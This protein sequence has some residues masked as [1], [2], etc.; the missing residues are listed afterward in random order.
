MTPRHIRPAESGWLT[1]RG[2]TA[3]THEEYKHW[4]C[5]HFDADRSRRDWFYFVLNADLPVTTDTRAFY[6]HMT[7]CC[8]R[9]MKTCDPYF[10]LKHPA[11]YD[12]G[13]A[14]SVVWTPAVKRGTAHLHGWIRVSDSAAEQRVT[15]R[16]DKADTVISAPRTVAATVDAFKTSSRSDWRQFATDNVFVRHRDGHAAA[17]TPETL[18]HTLDY[19]APAR[20]ERRLYVMTDF[21]PRWVI[22]KENAS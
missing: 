5:R 3:E 14:I 19:L 1:F 20:K 13:K 6:R 10:P 11:R 12:A 17:E 21:A 22:R 18:A 7:D 9:A 2:T 16:D 4:I 8:H 15:I